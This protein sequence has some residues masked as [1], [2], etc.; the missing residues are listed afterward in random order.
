M[1]QPEITEEQREMV[2]EL[3]ANAIRK[4]AH[5]RARAARSQDESILH[6]GMAKRRSESSQR[7]IEGMRD[8]LRVLFAN[9]HVLADECME[10]AYA[11]AMGLPSRGALGRPDTPF[12]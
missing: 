1:R 2:V 5:V 6:A 11:R 7:Y 12:H 10:E 9:G 3:L 8:L 4:N